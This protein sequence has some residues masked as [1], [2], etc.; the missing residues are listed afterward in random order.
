MRKPTCGRAFFG[1]HGLLGDE[2]VECSYYDCYLLAIV[3]LS[4]YAR[5]R[6]GQA[7]TERP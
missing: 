2:V 3:G 1:L 4:D 7:N 5:Q 6:A